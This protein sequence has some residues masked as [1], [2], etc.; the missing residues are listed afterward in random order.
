MKISKDDAAAI[1]ARMY[2]ARHGG[3]A[4]HI[5]KDKIRELQKRGDASG[6]DAWTKVADQLPKVRADADSRKV[7]GRRPSG[8]SVLSCANRCVSLNDALFPKRAQT[9]P[10]SPINS[11]EVGATLN[12]QPIVV[13]R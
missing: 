7:S 10:I 1:Y 9:A 12:R 4:K 3:R 6:I 5:V 11:T 2:L 13:F 8:H